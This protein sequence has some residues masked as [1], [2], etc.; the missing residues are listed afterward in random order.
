MHGWT[1]WCELLSLLVSSNFRIKY[2]IC[3]NCTT[4][5][6]FYHPSWKKSE[7]TNNVIKFS[8]DNMT[9]CNYSHIGKLELHIIQGVLLS[10]SHYHLKQQWKDICP[11]VTFYPLHT[12]GPRN[13]QHLDLNNFFN[14][15][16][17][18]MGFSLPFTGSLSYI[19][20]W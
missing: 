12:W 3:R 6:W 20:A 17:N 4:I 11:R 14:F 16:A 8:K 9:N 10:F 13:V 1:W 5:S 2:K 7:L 18:Y 19:Y 15:H